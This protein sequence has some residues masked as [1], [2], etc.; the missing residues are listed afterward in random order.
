M[1]AFISCLSANLTQLQDKFNTWFHNKK[2]V[3]VGRTYQLKVFQRILTPVQNDQR[4]VVQ[5]CDIKL[6]QNDFGNLK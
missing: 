2:Q 3:I 4:H 1:D 5:M 6:L